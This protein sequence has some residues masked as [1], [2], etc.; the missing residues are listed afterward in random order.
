MVLQKLR[1]M[2]IASIIVDTNTEPQ[3]NER[4]LHWSGTL[5]KIE[6]ELANYNVAE[7]NT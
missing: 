1:Q 7:P 6:A 3:P 5:I 4:T 2:L